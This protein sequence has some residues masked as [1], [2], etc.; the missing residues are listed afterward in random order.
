[1]PLSSWWRAMWEEIPTQSRQ[2]IDT[3][4]LRVTGQT[5]EIHELEKGMPWVDQAGGEGGD[6]ARAGS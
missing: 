5:G 3:S 1:M 2:A 6:S 4:K